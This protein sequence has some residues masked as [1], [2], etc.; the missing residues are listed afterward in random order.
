MGFHEECE[1][2]GKFGTRAVFA[3]GVALVPVDREISD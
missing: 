3:A 2:K 1:R